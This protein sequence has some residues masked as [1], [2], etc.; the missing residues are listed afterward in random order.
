MQVHILK[1]GRPA[2][3]SYESLAHRFASRLKGQLRLCSHFIPVKNNPRHAEDKVLQYLDACP[4][5]YLVILDE[6][7]VAMSSP[8]LAKRWQ[9]WLMEPQIKHLVFLIGGPYGLS[10]ELK[11]RADFQWSLAH[12]VYPSDLAWVM[13]MEQIYRSQMILKGSPYHH[14]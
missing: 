9:G 8:E 4:L 6:G 2:Y 1:M 11:N 3:D 13:V 10:L 7:G 14:S 5:G 12:G